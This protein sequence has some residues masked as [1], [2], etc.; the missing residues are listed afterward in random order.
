MSFDDVCLGASVKCLRGLLLLAGGLLDCRQTLLVSKLH[1]DT[2]TH[3][4]GLAEASYFTQLRTRCFSRHLIVLVKPDVF[5]VH[6]YSFPVVCWLFLPLGHRTGPS[7]QTRDGPFPSKPRENKRSMVCAHDTTPKYG[8]WRCWGPAPFVPDR[9]LTVDTDSAE[10][11]LHLLSVSPKRGVIFSCA[12]W[13]VL[14]RCKSPGCRARLSFSAGA[15][16]P[17]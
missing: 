5:C 12:C 13:R 4:F 9:I 1:P 6:S 16:H 2:S 3:L 17:R 14:P 7:S 10:V 11:A 15:F 8:W